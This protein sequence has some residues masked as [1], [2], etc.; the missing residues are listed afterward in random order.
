MPDV[1]HPRNAAFLP[2][3][4]VGH[5]RPAHLLLVAPGMSPQ[6]KGLER[7]R[8][9]PL[10]A[11]ALLAG[12]AAAPVHRAPEAK[13]TRAP[14]PAAS[15]VR[16]A[17]DAWIAAKIGKPSH[18]PWWWTEIRPAAPAAASWEDVEHGAYVLVCAGDADCWLL[19]DADRAVAEID[20]RLSWVERA[21]VLEALAA[22][23]VS[24]LRAAR[25][26]QEVP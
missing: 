2:R 12:C 23:D 16:A 20:G 15:P 21:R 5:G 1:R 8:L 4:P 24:N 6:P 13:Q 18:H 26:H 25:L 10:A 17:L 11:L 3:V 7:R 19:V 22:I 9:T 14:A